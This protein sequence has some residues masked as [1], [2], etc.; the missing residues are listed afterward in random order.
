MRVAAR[1]LQAC[2]PQRLLDQVNWRPIVER[3]RAVGM[4]QP[5]RRGVALDADAF[6]GSLHDAEDLLSGQRPTLL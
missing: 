1:R 5:V 3:V 6:G 4:P 2:M